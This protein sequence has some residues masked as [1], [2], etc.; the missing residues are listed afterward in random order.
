MDVA[1]PFLSR[2][3]QEKIDETEVR[4]GKIL[5]A[6]D[7]GRLF[8]DN[9]NNRV[10]ITD[11]VKGLKYSEIVNLKSP[12][13]KIYLSSDSH[14]LLLYDFKEEKWLCFSGGIAPEV[15]II[16]IYFKDDGKLYLKYGDGKEKECG[17]QNILL[18]KIS[19]MQTTIN[20]LEE[21]INQL[22]EIIKIQE[23]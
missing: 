14:Q 11:F 16:D 15:A 8:I 1:K 20:D 21:T 22:T 17:S 18:D 5:F 13:Q 3:L 7:T 2:G 19:E 6:T 10:E 4:D 12:L 9:K 23:L